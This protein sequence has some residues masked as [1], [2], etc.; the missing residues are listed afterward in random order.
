MIPYSTALEEVSLNRH[1]PK[2]IILDI[3]PWELGINQGKYEKLTAL[4]PYCDKHNEL[5]KYIKDISPFETYKLLSKS[6]PYNSSTFILATNTLFP[7]SVKK[8]NF[9]YLPLD[10][11]MTSTELKDYI[12][13]MNERSVR[14][15][16]KKN[17]VDEKAKN[18]FVDFLNFSF[19]NKIKTLVVISPTI[20]NN[21]FELDNQIMQKKLIIGIC[22]RYSNVTFVD[23]S[24]DFHFNY[25]PEKFS[26]VF[27]LNTQGSKE[28]SSILTS[29]IKSKYFN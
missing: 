14:I 27:H 22:G 24:T 5:I 18:Y 9:G 16:Q 7:N 13:R 23:Y 28:F 15:H 12:L 1:K 25:H 8:D 3:N 19:K 6:Y 4:L 20:L 11:K 17:F 2:L 26:D 10:G 21:P 29:D